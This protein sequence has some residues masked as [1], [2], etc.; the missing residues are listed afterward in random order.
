MKKLASILITV[1]LLLSFSACSDSGNKYGNDEYEVIAITTYDV[2]TG[3]TEQGPLEESY[4]T[5]IYMD[6]GDPKLV[7]DYYVK[8]EE[9]Y[10]MYIVVGDAN[11]FVT[12]RS[13]RNKTSYL[14][15]T[16]E[17]YDKLFS[18]VATSE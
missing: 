3:K 13:Y 14:Y 15:L 11:K 10:P 9:Y 17:T 1:C 18:G 2:I 16:Q 4:I 7:K 6:N 8:D 12:V 5:F